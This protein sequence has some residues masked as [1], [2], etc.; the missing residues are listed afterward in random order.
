VKVRER[1]VES[2]VKY[3]IYIF[4]CI[5]ELLESN[6]CNSRGVRRGVAVWRRRRRRRRRRKRRKRRMYPT[7]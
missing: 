7:S 6:S 2:N 1:L 3:S 4:L 5:K